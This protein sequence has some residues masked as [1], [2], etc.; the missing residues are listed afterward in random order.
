MYCR[1]MWIYIWGVGIDVYCIYLM[2][3]YCVGFPKCYSVAPCPLMVSQVR[4]EGGNALYK[5][6]V[7]SVDV[8][9]LNYYHC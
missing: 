4:W 7:L 6:C 8:L 5:R 9:G 2:Y 3:I 1:C